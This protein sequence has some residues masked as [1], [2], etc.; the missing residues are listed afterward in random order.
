MPTATNITFFKTQT[1][2]RTWFEKNKVQFPNYGSDFIKKIPEKLPQPTK[3]LSMKLSVSDGS[4]A[5]EKA[6]TRSVIRIGLR[7]A[8]KK[9]PGAPSTLNVLVN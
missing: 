2:L 8:R 9:A 3:K 6:S 4:M 1:A 7:R 5:F